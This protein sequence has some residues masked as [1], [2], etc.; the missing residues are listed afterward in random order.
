MF[1]ESFLIKYNILNLSSI[2][3]NV[4]KALSKDGIKETELFIAIFMERQ[5]KSSQNQLVDNIT[6]SWLMATGND[7]RIF[8][9]LE[10]PKR[11]HR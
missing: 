4:Q 10:R 8:Q 2:K 1:Q 5:F 7:A 6:Q 9:R 3:F 11:M